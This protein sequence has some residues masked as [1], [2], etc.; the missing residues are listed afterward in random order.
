MS[1][2][3]QRLYF[4]DAI[5]AFAIIMMLQG[6]FVHTLLDT[7]LVNTSGFFYGLWE[8]FRGITAPTFFT[9]TGFVFT[10]LLLKKNDAVSLQNPRVKKGLRRGLKL[11][12][13]GYVLRFNLS[14]FVVGFKDFFFFIDVLHIIGLSLILLIGLYLL[15]YRYSARLFQYTLLGIG[16]VVFLLERSYANAPLE[17]LPEFF[18]NYFTKAHGSVFTIFPWFG[19][20]ALGSFLSIIFLRQYQKEGFY[21]LAIYNLAIVGLLLVHFSSYFLMVLFEFTGIEIFKASAGYNYLFSRFGDVLVLFSLFLVIRRWMAK[22]I[23]TDLGGRTLSIYILH[24]ILLYGSWLGIGFSR[25]WHHSLSPL[26]VILGAIAFIMIIC[27]TVL[28]YYRFGDQWIERGK[29]IAM[30][31][32]SMSGSWLVAVIS[33]LQPIQAIVLRFRNR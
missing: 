16:F 19:Y 13:W 32:I 17:L 5:R 26:Q 15:L 18:A 3:S 29:A 4:I 7:S 1:A 12:F 31:K 9:I 21:R 10:F 28:L 20:V 30:R 6:H 8:Y 2:R 11:L 33:K 14:F 23:F 25:Y 22:S 27:T 24:Y